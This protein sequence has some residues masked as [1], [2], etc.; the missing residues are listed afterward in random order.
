VEK[1]LMETRFVVNPTS[2]NGATGKRWPAIQERLKSTYPFK[3]EAVFTERPCHETELAREGI[4]K[5]YER[6]VSVGGDGTLNGVLNGFIHEDRLLRENVALGVLEIGTGA[7]FA[8]TLGFPSKIEEA[9]GWLSRLQAK[10]IDVGKARFCSL[11]GV[12]IVR[13]FINILDFGIGGAVVERVN[14]TTKRFGGRISFLWGILLTLL[15]YQNKR[16]RYRLDG[17]EWESA[18]LNNYIVANGRYFGGGLF[19]A[20]RAELDDGWFDVVLFGDI[21]RLE[22]IRALPRLRSG[23]HLSHP[24]VLTRKAREVEA[25]SDEDVWIDMDGDLVGRLPI[26]ISIMPGLLPFLK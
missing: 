17:G 22:A 7:D 1:R 20:P 10:R 2:A 6:I 4:L 14:R 16:I 19:P 8:K 25:E 18:V 11:E 9:I 3:F 13:Y 5:G 12:E 21:G 15:L 26:T 24:D 23:A